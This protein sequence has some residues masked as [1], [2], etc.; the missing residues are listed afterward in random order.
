MGF[1]S[2]DSRHPPSH[3]YLKLSS[4]YLDKISREVPH[5]N[6]LENLLTKMETQSKLSLS[7]T[8]HYK[9]SSSINLRRHSEEVVYVKFK[10]KYISLYP[11]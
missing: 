5:L 1:L 10:P 4:H 11:P 2:R 3:N 9:G 7:L 6:S 8:A